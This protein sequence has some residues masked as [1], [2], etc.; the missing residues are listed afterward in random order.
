VVDGAAITVFVTPCVIINAAINSPFSGLETKRLLFE[1]QD[2]SQDHKSKRLRCAELIWCELRCR[3][4]D[5]DQGT[6]RQVGTHT[7]ASV[8]VVGTGAAVSK[9]GRA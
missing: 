9:C 8:H 2:V 3:H 6:C 5:V 7:F 1:Q 4:G